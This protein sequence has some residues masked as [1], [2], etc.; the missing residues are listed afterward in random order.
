MCWKHEWARAVN[1]LEWAKIHVQRAIIKTTKRHMHYA[2]A[3]GEKLLQEL[4]RIQ[5]ELKEMVD[6][7]GIST[8]QAAKSVKENMDGRRKKR[9]KVQDW[10][11]HN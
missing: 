5:E 9:G 8:K 4:T 7:Y 2:T 3:R 11:E 1:N 6:T 10:V